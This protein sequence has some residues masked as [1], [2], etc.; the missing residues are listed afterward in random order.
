MS[1]NLG[2]PKG[3]CFS[4]SSP[5]ILTVAHV[6]NGADS[7]AAAGV[8]DAFEAHIM[9]VLSWRLGQATILSASNILQ[10]VREHTTTQNWGLSYPNF[11]VYSHEGFSR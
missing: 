6:K 11:Q 2:C 7:S 3:T 1:G 10:R 8:V 9:G 4:D 5:T